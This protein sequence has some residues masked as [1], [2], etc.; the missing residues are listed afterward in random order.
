MT[1]II[2]GI[3]EIYRLS[4]SHSLSSH[5]FISNSYFIHPGV[6]SSPFS[7]G[8]VV[9]HRR[10]IRDHKKTGEVKEVEATNG[11]SP[12]GGDRFHT[13]FLRVADFLSLSFCSSLPTSVLDEGNSS[14]NILKNGNKCRNSIGTKKYRFLVSFIQISSHFG[15]KFSV[16]NRIPCH[17]LAIIRCEIGNILSIL[18][19]MEW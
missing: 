2:K 15:L 8:G 5:E 16:L 12:L 1:S 9:S 4:P 10:T 19:L 3:M 17:W 18:T 13:Y 14:F 11:G 6:A 7:P